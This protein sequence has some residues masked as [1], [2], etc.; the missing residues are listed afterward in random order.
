VSRAAPSVELPLH[1]TD[2]ALLAVSGM[3]AEKATRAAERLVN[4]NV[5]MLAAVGFAGAI[6][7]TLRPGAVLLPDTI[8][9]AD[10]RSFTIDKDLHQ[11]VLTMLCH[12]TPVTVS[13]ML[14]VAK[15]ITDPQ[16]KTALRDRHQAVAVDM[17]SAAVARVARAHGLPFIAL[18]VVLDDANM[19][20]PAHLLA[21]ADKLGRLKVGTGAVTL[22]AHPLEAF[23]A[24]RLLRAL[25]RARPA[26][27]KA[28]Q[29]LL[30]ATAN[31]KPAAR[32]T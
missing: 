20:L 1:V 28:A 18:R 15:L 10:G 14:E 8:L 31:V 29:T 7:P 16:Q 12:D 2:H 4:R 30:R 25:G 26:L 5:A 24:A 13:P 17:E 11:K 21:S 23:T 6:E 3:G 22:L 19:R 27:R 9:A 32:Q